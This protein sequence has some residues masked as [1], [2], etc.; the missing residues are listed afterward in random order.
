ML[1]G[2]PS[3]RR[4]IDKCISV[5]IKAGGL[6][7]GTEWLGCHAVVAERRCYVYGGGTASEGIE[8]EWRKGDF[9]RSCGELGAGV[10]KPGVPRW[11][12]R[13]HTDAMPSLT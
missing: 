7:I 9:A 13:I 3:S 12:L 8:L 10:L 11:G 6:T 5:N 1:N 4:V 2:V